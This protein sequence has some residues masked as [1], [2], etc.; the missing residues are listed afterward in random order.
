[1]RQHH[2]SRRTPGAHAMG[3]ITL[4]ELIVALGMLATLLAIVIPYYQS[5]SSK[6]RTT[7]TLT[8]VSG[9]Q[10]GGRPTPA[11]PTTSSPAS[12]GG[13]RFVP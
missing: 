5:H 4:I 3:G 12:P 8:E 2:P 6:A 10:V 11:C 1:M 7:A 9:T 13:Q